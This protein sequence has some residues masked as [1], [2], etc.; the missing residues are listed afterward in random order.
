MQELLWIAAGVGVVLVMAAAIWAWWAHRQLLIDVQR[1]LQW[2]EQSRFALERHAQEVDLRLAAMA[3][4]LQAMEGQRAPPVLPPNEA[5]ER[6]R[7]M[8][9]ALGRADAAAA[10]TLAQAQ[11]AHANP[12]KDTEPLPLGDPTYAP[13][14]PM[15]L[16]EEPASPAQRQVAAG[17]TRANA[18]PAGTRTGGSATSPKPPAKHPLKQ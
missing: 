7:F 6:R 15:P 10:A 2:S 9:E 13:T 4:S 17:A 3:H 1:R 11:P 16:R 18:G 8:E 12:W 14:M 5:S